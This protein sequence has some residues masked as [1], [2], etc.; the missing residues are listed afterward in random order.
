MAKCVVCGKEWDNTAYDDI[1][2]VV[3]QH[4]L[5]EHNLDEEWTLDR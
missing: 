5:T 4:I 2:S 3:T 1:V